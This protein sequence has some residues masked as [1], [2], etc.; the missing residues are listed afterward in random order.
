MG[1]EKRG[2]MVNKLRYGRQVTIN[3]TTNRSKRN[4]SG[5]CVSDQRE[6]GPLRVPYPEKESSV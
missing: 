1:E 6:S 3:S 2:K 4:Q 5:T